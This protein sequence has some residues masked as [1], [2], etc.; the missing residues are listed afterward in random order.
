[1]WSHAQDDSVSNALTMFPTLADVINLDSEEDDSEPDAAATTPLTPNPSRRNDLYMRRSKVR[2]AMTGLPIDELGLFTSVALP[3]GALVGFYT[4]HFIDEERYTALPERAR[5]LLNRYAVGIDEHELTIAP[6]MAVGANHPD[7]QMHA[8][9]LINEPSEGER[10]NVF[11]Q[12]RVLDTGYH[13]VVCVLMYTCRPIGPNGELL[14]WYGGAY[15]RDGRYVPGEGCT[16]ESI[17]AARLEDPLPMLMA[18]VGMAHV[19][20][21]L[22]EHSDASSGDEWLP[23]PTRRKRGY[24]G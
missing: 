24:V 5:E 12:T 3:A 21:P 18:C 10:S 22:P 11:A 6:P 19:Y 13:Q 8:M 9:G 16:A 4:G 15:N 2:D 1:M 23:P 17:N 20:H 14:W 7:F